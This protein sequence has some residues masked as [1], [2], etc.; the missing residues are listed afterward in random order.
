MLEAGSARRP[1]QCQCCRRIGWCPAGGSCSQQHLLCSC[2]SPLPLASCAQALGG[3]P[4]CQGPRP[5][6]C[7]LCL[8]AGAAFALSPG[9]GQPQHPHRTGRPATCHP[10]IH[11][12]L[13]AVADAGRSR[14]LGPPLPRSSVAQREASHRGRQGPALSGFAPRHGAWTATLCLLPPPHPELCPGR[15]RLPGHRTGTP[16]LCSALCS[17]ASPFPLLSPGRRPPGR[18]P[19]PAAASLADS[20]SELCPK[21]HRHAHARPLQSWGCCTGSVPRKSGGTAASRRVLVE[22][23][24]MGVSREQAQGILGVFTV[25]QAPGWAAVSSGESAQP[26]LLWRGWYS[27]SCSDIWGGLG[28]PGATLCLPYAMSRLEPQSFRWRLLSN[29]QPARWTVPCWQRPA[30]APTQE[31]VWRLVMVSGTAEQ[32]SL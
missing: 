8:P 7:G 26:R 25:Q 32:P 28:L 19:R 31:V 30:P 15:R 16:R 9:A 17:G 3:I 10:G 24:L 12:A 4:A 5:A 1:S 14:C 13:P 23:L 6:Q 21:C 18:R 2:K 11:P 22:A 29:S 27:G 20:P